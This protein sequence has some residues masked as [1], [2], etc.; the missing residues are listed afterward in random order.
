M[1]QVQGLDSAPG[2]ETL[3]DDDDDDDDD[4]NNNNN[5]NNI[6]KS[7]SKGWHSSKENYRFHHAVRFLQRRSQ[8]RGKLLQQPRRT[9]QPRSQSLFVDEERGPGWG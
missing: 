5:T 2:E 1:P 4:N 8:E 7:Y 9:N 3:D 6:I